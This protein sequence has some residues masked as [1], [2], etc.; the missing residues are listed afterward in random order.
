MHAGRRRDWKHME[1]HGCRP[2]IVRSVRNGRAS[3]EHFVTGAGFRACLLRPRPPHRTKPHLSCL[4]SPRLTALHELLR[5]PSTPLQRTPLRRRS[6]KY[7]PSRG[8]AR[9]QRH[10]IRSDCVAGVG[11]PATSPATV[12]DRLHPGAFTSPGTSTRTPSQLGLFLCHAL[13]PSLAD[14]AFR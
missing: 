5:P 12:L 2:P 9:E 13:A 1:R 7:C 8:H 14:K 6:R 11:D 10:R 4:L 3:E